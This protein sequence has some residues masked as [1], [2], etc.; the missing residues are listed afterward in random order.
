MVMSWDKLGFVFDVGTAD[1]P[2][3]VEVER[4]LPRPKPIRQGA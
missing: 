2:R 1:R 3:F 4:R